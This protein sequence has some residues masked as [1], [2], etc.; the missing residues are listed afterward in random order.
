[1]QEI[2]QTASAPATFE[3]F[4]KG[5]EMAKH[6]VEEMNKVRESGFEAVW[7]ALVDIL[8]NDTAPLLKFT[9]SVANV[10]LGGFQDTADAKKL[11]QDVPE[12]LERGLEL[13]AAEQ[14]ETFVEAARAL[15]NHPEEG[16][17]AIMDMHF[18]SQVLEIIE[19]F[20]GR[21][22]WDNGFCT[23]ETETAKA[24]GGRSQFQSYSIE[25][26]HVALQCRHSGDQ[27]LPRPRRPSGGKQITS[28]L[29]PPAPPS[30]VQQLLA[31]PSA[32][33][34]TYSFL[35]LMTPPIS[36]LWRA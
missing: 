25:A 14:T 3:N 30:L 23:A 13:I 32:D 27:S 11:L 34:W 17:S 24:R 15:L 33:T 16:S 19:A 28:A 7:D 26:G 31:S 10:A 20:P 5:F 21:A 6:C 2:A 35:V 29:A 36:D 8:D 22:L 4:E 9:D 18:I 12:S 1:M